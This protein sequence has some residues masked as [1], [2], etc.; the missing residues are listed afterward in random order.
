VVGFFCSDEVDGFGVV[1]ILPM[2]GWCWEVIGGPDVSGCGVLSMLGIS[3]AEVESMPGFGEVGPGRS[4]VPDE[5]EGLVLSD[6]TATVLSGEL[7]CIVFA[8]DIDDAGTF[9]ELGV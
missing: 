9:V 8:V 7:G 6:V 3:E 5:V 1:E 2:D 4:V